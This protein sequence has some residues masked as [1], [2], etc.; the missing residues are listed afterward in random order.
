MWLPV[1]VLLAL[2]LPGGRAALAAE[3]GEIRGEMVR[4][5]R[6][7]RRVATLFWLPLEYW[8]ASARE[9]GAG[10]EELEA[11]HKL[12]R[13]YVL[14]GVVDVELAQD[15]RPAFKSIADIVS[16]ST[17]RRN[18]VELEV[19]RQPNPELA[20]RVPDLVYV[21]RASLGALGAGLRVLPLANVGPGGQPVLLGSRAGVLSLEFRLSEGAE[22]TSISWRAPL[23]AIVGAKTCPEGDELLE[24]SF[25]FCPWHGVKLTEG[26]AD[27]R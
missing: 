16:R 22:P 1:L 27:P 21:L 3:T 25:D 15:G 17:F 4:T 20:S 12:F 13:D 18:G 10:P 26:T 11:V 2:L 23:T 7:G 9:R 8:E 14:V 19:L 6:D 24:A 5:L